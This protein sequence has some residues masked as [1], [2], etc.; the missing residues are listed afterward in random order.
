MLPIH[1]YII[2][3]G[4]KN[5][6][7]IFS[8][9]MLGCTLILWKIILHSGFQVCKTNTIMQNIKSHNNLSVQQF[10]RLWNMSSLLKV[11]Q[12]NKLFQQV[13][14]IL[15]CLKICFSSFILFSTVLV[16]SWLLNI[17]IIVLAKP[18]RAKVLDWA[19]QND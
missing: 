1:F 5:E 16:A 6:K 7:K 11:H 17:L 14:Q 19:R 10:G 15:H 9:H 18:N 8:A 4:Q 3:Y 2:I 13:Y 12:A